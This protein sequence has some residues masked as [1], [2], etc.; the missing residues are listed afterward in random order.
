MPS[1]NPDVYNWDNVLFVVG[2]SKY[3]KTRY[4]GPD[5]YFLTEGGRNQYNWQTG[6]FTNYNA[7]VQMKPFDCGPCH[8]TGYDSL[9][10]TW[11][12]P[13]VTCEGCHGP[14]ER[15]NEMMV[16]GQELLG[17]GEEARGQALLDEAS[18]LSREAVSRRLVP[19]DAGDINVCVTCHHPWRHRDGGPGFLEREE[20][21]AGADAGR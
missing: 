17:L 6:S 14:G 12:E 21:V 4:V 1:H 16:V 9:S 3:W 5:G 8:T 13:G 15:Y 10:G 2:A 19:G 18:R 11:A 20:E 7:D